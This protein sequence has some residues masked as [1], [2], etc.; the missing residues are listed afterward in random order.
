MSKFTDL[1]GFCHRRGTE[2]QLFEAARL[3]NAH[4][5]ICELKDGYSPTGIIQVVGQ[6]AIQSETWFSK[7]ILSIFHFFRILARYQ[8]SHDALSGCKFD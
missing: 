4:G 5:F 2:E 3:A 6:N 7:E 8:N 1:T